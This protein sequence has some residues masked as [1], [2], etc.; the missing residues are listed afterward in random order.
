MNSIFLDLE[1]TIIQS[2]YDPTLVNVGRI[3]HTLHKVFDIRE[4]GIFS[5]AVGNERDRETTIKYLV[6]VIERALEVTVDLNRIVTCEE[7]VQNSKELHG[8]HYESW[9][10]YINVVGKGGAFID[11]CRLH[12]VGLNSILID[13]CVRNSTTIDHDTDT[14]IRLLPV[15]LLTVDRGTPL[16]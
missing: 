3:K 12:Q 8:C 13:D 1:E 7:M 2:W 5:F 9:A 16:R 10:D 4:V 15:Q 6:P 11:H 14:T